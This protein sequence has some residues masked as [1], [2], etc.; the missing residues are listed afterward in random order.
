VEGLR[1]ACGG[2]GVVNWGEGPGDDCKCFE[3]LW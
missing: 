2:G 3:G 1:K